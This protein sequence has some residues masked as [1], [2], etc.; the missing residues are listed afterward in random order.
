[1]KLLS[2]ESP[3]ARITQA[4]EENPS[5]ES[6]VAA[7]SFRH[8][9]EGREG[10]SATT[11][12]RRTPVRKYCNKGHPF[13][14]DNVMLHKDGSRR[15]RICNTNWQRSKGDWQGR[16]GKNWAGAKMFCVNGHL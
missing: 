8:T 5:P 12:P 13:E 1:M 16:T 2:G 7:E 10:T 11:S 6:S 4:N 14:G 9:L 3:P 15:C